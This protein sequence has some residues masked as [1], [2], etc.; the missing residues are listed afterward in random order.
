MPTIKAYSHYVTTRPTHNHSHN[1]S[2]KRTSHKTCTQGLHTSYLQVTLPKPQNIQYPSV[3]QYIYFKI[4]SMS[5]LVTGDLSLCR[6]VFIT[7]L[8]ITDLFSALSIPFTLTDAFSHTWPFGD[9][10]TS[11]RL[12]TPHVAIRGLAHLLQV[13]H[14][15]PGHSGTRLSPAG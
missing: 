4:N 3:V 8:A 10:L 7:Q 1:L 15:P 2:L 12:D 13:R 5:G 14:L 6:R 11:C 9:S